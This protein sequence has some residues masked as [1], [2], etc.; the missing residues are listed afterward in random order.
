MSLNIKKSTL[1]TIAV[2]LVIV[3]VVAV[4][5]YQALYAAPP[6]AGTKYTTG[7]TVK[8]KLYDSANYSL[9]T[10]SA[11]VAFYDAGV[12]AIGV[13][14]FTTKPVAV[15]SYDSVNGYWSVPLDAG[16]YVALAQDTKASKTWYPEQITV[17][18][19]GTNQESKEVW[20]DP[21]QLNVYARATPAITK[22]I[23]AYNATSGAYDVVVTTLNY[24]AY[25]KWVVTYTLTISDGS[26]S[27][28]IKDGRLYMTK[29]TALTPTQVSVDGV[30][31]DVVD[32]TDASDDGQSGY[33]TTITQMT[34]GE[35]HRVDVYFEDSGVTAGTLTAKLWEYSALLRTGT[36]LHYWTDK[37]SAITVE[38]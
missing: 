23:L 7:L 6:V 11:Q 38:A 22:G 34:A 33:Y 20:L 36:T 9:I 19:S 3:V 16:T 4:L 8:F 2:I 17:T 32:D 24:T 26:T 28:I 1:A 27:A 35:I 14:T 25:D 5:A 21:S 13:R 29:L 18:V 12:D 30:V 10:S 15:A 37:T 31:S